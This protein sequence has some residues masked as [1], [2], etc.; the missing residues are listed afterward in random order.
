M[1]FLQVNDGL[2]TGEKSLVVREKSPGG[3]L[4]EELPLEKKSKIEEDLEQMMQII[5]GSQGKKQ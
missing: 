4:V 2:A 1:N 3:G 5:T